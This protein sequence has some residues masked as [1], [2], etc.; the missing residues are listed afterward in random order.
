[1]RRTRS[2]IAHPPTQPYN[3]AHS[4][5]QAGSS[6]ALK[7]RHRSPANIPARAARFSAA[8]S[9]L[10]AGQNHTE[11]AKVQRE[12]SADVVHPQLPLKM[13]HRNA[14]ALP[15]RAPCPR[16]SLASLIQVEEAQQAR[17][18]VPWRCPTAEPQTP[19]KPRRQI[20]TPM[21]ARVPRFPVRRR[22]TQSSRNQQQNCLSSNKL[23]SADAPMPLK[24]RHPIP[25]GMP[26]RAPRLAA[27]DSSLH[28]SLESPKEAG[29]QSCVSRERSKR[30]CR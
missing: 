1:M 9:L 25:Q 14:A 22:N 6:T 24:T 11:R 21:P 12:S 3:T 29:V 10:G 7:T 4:G 13:R 16:P 30:R 2:G 27:A 20:P 8:D 23:R 18:H 28:V 15:V 5:L 26:A 17:C 19:R